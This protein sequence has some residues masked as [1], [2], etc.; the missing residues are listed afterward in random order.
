MHF[1][2]FQKTELR[3]LQPSNTLVPIEVTLFPIAIDI[4]LLQ[5]SNV[6]L[7]IEV[8]LFG[9]STDVSPQ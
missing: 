2:A 8:T 4:R 7:P 1:F 9:I 3:F 6:E 5:S